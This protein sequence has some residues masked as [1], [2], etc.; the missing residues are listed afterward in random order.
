LASSEGPALGFRSRLQGHSL[1]FTG[2]SAAA[3]AVSYAFYAVLARNL[4]V[5]EFGLAGVYISV[6]GL[7]S[8]VS[9]A[10]IL[11]VAREVSAEGTAASAAAVRAGAIKPLRRLSVAC[12]VAGA[13]LSPFAVEAALIL[14]AA[15]LVPLRDLHCG[16]LNGLRMNA[17]FGIV[18]LTESSVR[19][20]GA[21]A[22]IWFPSA[23]VAL[24]AWL[25]SYATGLGV[26]IVFLPRAARARSAPSSFAAGLRESLLVRLP[27]VSFLNSD[28]ILIPVVLGLKAEVGIYVA[29]AILSRVPFYLV[30]AHAIGE[31]P[32]LVR[33]QGA[34]TAAGRVALVGAA[35][36]GAM[37][38]VIW[39]A[40][41]WVLGVAFGPSYATGDQILL[42]LSFTG[43]LL[44][45]VNSV[46]YTLISAGR[47]MQAAVVLGVGALAEIL[48]ILAMGPTGGSAGVAWTTAM[49]AGGSLLVMLLLLVMSM[50]LRRAPMTAS[51]ASDPL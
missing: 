2:L 31:L 51:T 38:A 19:L 21:F 45:Q 11:A 46:A 17:Q 44:V 43:F 48:L 27:L 15:A 33:E 47:G 4:Q 20:A 39:A 5:P 42:I 40:P 35:A 18:I 34:G 49:A 37:V 29:A 22:T 41:Q 24:L 13:A 3:Y 25:L 12:V 8:L 32:N 6:L 16:L 1:L 14:F 7:G 50:R 30:T 36:T 28:V 26:A 23:Q 9:G 10:L